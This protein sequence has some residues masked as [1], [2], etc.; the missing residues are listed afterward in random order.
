MATVL[1]VAKAQALLGQM[2]VIL[3]H[4]SVES[5]AVQTLMDDRMLKWWCNIAEKKPRGFQEISFV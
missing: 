5:N 2:E 1:C 3:V 4:G